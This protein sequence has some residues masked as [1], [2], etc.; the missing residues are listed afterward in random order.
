MYFEKFTNLPTADNVENLFDY[1]SIIQGIYSTFK[2]V[3][4]LE[5]FPFVY[6]TVIYILSS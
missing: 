6:L 4:T 1:Q 5:H 3:S 2:Q